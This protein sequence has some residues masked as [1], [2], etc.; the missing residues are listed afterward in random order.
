MHCELVALV[1]FSVEVQLVTGVQNR[2]ASAPHSQQAAS[3]PAPAPAMAE[4]ATAPPGR[5]GSSPAASQEDVF[6]VLEKLGKLRDAGIV[7][8]EEFE[9]KKKQLLDRI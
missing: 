7:T 1:Q 6:E 9:T 4:S 8:P 3:S 5:P 2:Q